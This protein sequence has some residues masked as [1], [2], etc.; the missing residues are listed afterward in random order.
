MQNFLDYIPHREPFLFVDRVIAVT[1]KS[2]QTEKRVKAEEPFFAGHFPGR[3]IMPGV[4]ICEAVFQSGAI[5]ISRILKNSGTSAIES[6]K[7][8][9]LTRIKDVKF[10]SMVRPDDVLQMQVE[11]S[12]IIGGAFFMKGVAKV[13]GK[14]A[15]R[16][17]FAATLTN[18]LDAD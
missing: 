13:D 2:I 18:N 15:V 5:L 16:V 6:E 4:L 9:V 17:E 10:K 11:I 3:P 8:P 12:E 1:E 7:I 14:V